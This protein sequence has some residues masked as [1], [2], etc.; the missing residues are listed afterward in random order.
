MDICV[1]DGKHRI[2][3]SRYEST[4]SGFWG[5]AAAQVSQKGGRIKCHCCR[6]GCILLPTLWSCLVLE[7]AP[8]PRASPCSHEVGS[9]NS[10]RIRHL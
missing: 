9:C 8:F 1:W 10:P 3:H 2:R 6:S 7:P 5:F 4:N